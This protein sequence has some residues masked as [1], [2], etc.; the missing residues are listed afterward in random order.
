[1]PLS[2]KGRLRLRDLALRPVSVDTG[3]DYPCSQKDLDSYVRLAHGNQKEF[4]GQMESTY[5]LVK[6]NRLSKELTRREEK[7]LSNLEYGLSLRGKISKCGPDLV[8]KAF[9]DLDELFFMGLLHGNCRVNWVD[10]ETLCAIR[11]KPPR[12]I[13]GITRPERRG[14]AAIHLNADDIFLCMLDPFMVMFSTLLHECWWVASPG[15]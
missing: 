5:Q 14:Q 11:Q 6:W 7:A 2:E 8:I 13:L 9:R 10:T 15:K 4:L 1:M 3:T 12:T